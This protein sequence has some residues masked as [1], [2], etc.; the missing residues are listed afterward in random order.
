MSCCPEGAWPEGPGK[1][2]PGFTLG[3]WFIVRGPEEVPADEASRS[4]IPECRVP[5]QGSVTLERVSQG[6]PWA[7]LSWPFGPKTC[8]YQ[9][10]LPPRCR[11]TLNT[12]HRANKP[13][14]HPLASRHSA[15]TPTTSPNQLPVA[16]VA[17]RGSFGG[18]RCFPGPRAQTAPGPKT[19]RHS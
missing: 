1:D 10:M 15:L 3:F 4:H 8:L 18:S 13:P 2:S 5:F 14:N 19:I 9:L 17:S 12:S 6:G 7:M 16:Q 11:P